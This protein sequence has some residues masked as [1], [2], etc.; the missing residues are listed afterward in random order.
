MI[1]SHTLRSKNWLLEVQ[2][3][4]GGWGMYEH[5]PSRI[6]TTAEAVTALLNI[7]GRTVEIDKGANYLLNA[8]GRPEWCQY[9]RHHSWVIHSLIRSGYRKEIPVRCIEA[10]RKS[11]NKGAWS[12]RL[13]GK[14]SI[15]ATFLALRACIGYEESTTEKYLKRSFNWIASSADNGRWSFDDREYS[16]VATSYALLSLTLNPEWKR[17]YSQLVDQAVDFLYSSI[18]SM[19]INEQEHNTSGDFTYNFHHFTLPWAIM[20]LISAGTP[21]FDE[22]ILIPTDVLYNEYFCN[23]TGGW[24]EQ[25]DHRPSVFATS[26][27]IEALNSLKE[28]F[29][30]FDLIKNFNVRKDMHNQI[31]NNKNQVFIVHGHNNEIKQEMARF[32]E[33]LGCSVVILEE[34]V[35]SGLTTIFEKFKRYATGASYAIIL[36]TP[37]DLPAISDEQMLARARQNVI[38]EMGFFIGKLGESAVC[39]AKKGKVNIPSDIQGILYLDLENGG[40]KLELASKLKKAG[41]NIDM[42][43]LI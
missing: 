5:D 36:L 31:I 42:S 10:L 16:P 37:D 29:N 20:A 1:D 12:H 14:P 7:T 43:N 39:L 41:L 3:E 27:T 6:V 8:A 40:W 30:A 13:N 2:N 33:K 23:P 11:Q 34:Q 9:T 38:L 24:S 35:D 32:L 4:D 21:I 17:D 19:S 28:A 18:G 25:I 15:F 22:K 26:H